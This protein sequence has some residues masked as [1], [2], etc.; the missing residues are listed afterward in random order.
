LEDLETYLSVTVVLNDTTVWQEE[1]TAENP[2]TKSEEYTE[3]DGDDPDL[4]KLPLDWTL[5]EVGVVVSN[6]NGSQISEQGEEDDEIGTDSLVDDEHRCDQVEF[7]VE[8]ES[9][10]VLNICLH[11]LE[12]L[13]SD[14]DG[15]DNGVKTRGEEDNIGGGLGSFGSTLDGNTTIRFLERWSIVDT[16]TSH[17]SKMST[18]L[19]HFDD[20]VLVLRENFSETI[21]LLNEIVLSRS[22]ETTVDET[23]RVINLGTEGKHLASFLSNSNSITSQHLDGKTENLSFSDSGSGIITRRIEHRKHSEE[24]PVLV[25]LLDGNTQRTE[26]TTSELSGLGLVHICDFLGAGGEVQDSLGRTLGTNEGNTILDNH[27]GNTFGDRV[28]RSEFLR[29]PSEGEDVLC[30]WVTLEGQD[31]DFVDRIEGLDVVGGRESRDGH[32]PVDIDTFSD[33]RLADG[34]LIGCERTGLVGTENIDTL[35]REALALAEDIFPDMTQREG[36]EKNASR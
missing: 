8:T 29:L 33:E 32:H 23:F 30:F 35:Q 25:T 16:V 6:G 28:E 18:L 15:R 14:L 11:T 13:T 17:G 5:L 2:S 20:L 31:G 21:G 27:S 24:L 1:G 7:Q 34:E 3:D 36:S 10:T 22:R 19:Q 4:W 12:N 26:S 9:D